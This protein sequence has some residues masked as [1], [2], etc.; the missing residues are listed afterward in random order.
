MTLVYKLALPSTHNADTWPHNEEW[1]RVPASSYV[2]KIVLGYAEEVWGIRRADGQPVRYSASKGVWQEDV[3]NDVAFRSIEHGCNPGQ[4]WGVDEKYRLREYDSNTGSWTIRRRGKVFQVAVGTAGVYAIDNEHSLIRLEAEKEKGRWVNLGGRNLHRIE[5]GGEGAVWAL[6]L[7]GRPI[8]IDAGKPHD[9][10]GHRDAMKDVFSNMSDGL[11]LDRER[12]DVMDLSD[13]EL[14]R[15][16]K[17][18]SLQ[19]GVVPKAV[20]NALRDIL[21]ESSSNEDEIAELLGDT[22]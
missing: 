7:H 15:T 3:G 2:D 17:A 5:A 8:I 20:E 16:S 1:N 9:D 11:P 13:E 4:L 19:A 21:R 10:S 14:A 6:D 12:D 18:Q 22:Q